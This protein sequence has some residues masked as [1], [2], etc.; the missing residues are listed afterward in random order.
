MGCVGALNALEV[1]LSEARPRKDYLD[2]PMTRPVILICEDDSDIRDLISIILQTR[3]SAQ[4]L[5]ASCVAE[6]KEILSKNMGIDCVISDYNLP[7]GRGNEVHRYMKDSGISAP[8]ILCST[9]PVS[10]VPSLQKEKNVFELPKPFTMEQLSTVVA[11]AMHSQEEPILD[12]EYCSLPLR[13]ISAAVIAPT[14]LFIKLSDSNYVKI[15]N[16]GDVFDEMD[17]MH[18]S[19]KNIHF[20]YVESKYFPNFINKLV[21]ETLELN[22]AKGSPHVS[23][24]IVSLTHSVLHEMVSAFG[25]SPE[26][27]E[28]AKNCTNLA[29][30]GISSS[31]TLAQYLVKVAKHPDNFLYFHSVLLA[32][33]VCLMASSVGW[34]SE[35]IQ[36]KLAYAAIMHDLTLDSGKM[37]ELEL[38]L[39]PKKIK[40]IYSNSNYPNLSFRE[41]PEDVVLLA[42]NDRSISEDI[43]N[44]L[45]THH[46]DPDGAGFPSQVRSRDFQPLSS[47]FVIAHS[48]TLHVVKNSDLTNHLFG[49]FVGQYQAK[50][51][52][53]PFKELFERISQGL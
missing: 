50:F 17:A 12:R 45:V 4:I 19:Q 32:Q 48:L 23:L 28:V 35:K 49:S 22:R 46:E 41:H 26:A 8:Y 21:S 15:C 9:V 30:R 20:I 18:T 1:I 24:E 14:D 11:K 34:T 36:Y 38:D 52:S 2:I 5:E 25:L 3:L 44:I 53:G 13:L 43:L 7:D 16:Q 47:L 10:D 29:L 42:K 6:A 51:S 31:G 40:E 37:A 39:D 33:I 27:Q